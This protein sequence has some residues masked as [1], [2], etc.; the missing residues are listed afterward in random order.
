MV[1]CPREPD[2]VPTSAGQKARARYV[3][4]LIAVGEECRK[5]ADGLQDHHRTPPPT[6]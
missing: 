1:P 3:E 5:T 4:Q 2:P 6:T